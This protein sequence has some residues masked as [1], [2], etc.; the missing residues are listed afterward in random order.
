VDAPSP[1]PRYRATILL[2]RFR[3]RFRFRTASSAAQTRWAWRA[4][5][6]TLRLLLGVVLLDVLVG[7]PHVVHLPAANGAAT[8]GRGERVTVGGAG[9]VARQRLHERDTHTNAF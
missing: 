1:C 2:A 7:H 6:Q 5:Y 9:G 8:E 3:F 4:A